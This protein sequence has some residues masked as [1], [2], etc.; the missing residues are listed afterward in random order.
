MKTLKTME[1]VEELI[2]LLDGIEQSVMDGLIAEGHPP[3]TVDQYQAMCV[4]IAMTV[5]ALEKDD[6]QEE[7][8]VPEAL[9]LELRRR[10]DAH[11]KFRLAYEETLDQAQVAFEA[12]VQSLWDQ[13]AERYAERTGAD[14]EDLPGPAIL[15]RH[16]GLVYLIEVTVSETSDDLSWCLMARCWDFEAASFLRDEAGAVQ[17]YWTP[18]A[19]P[20]HVFAREE[21]EPSSVQIETEDV[22]WL[23]KTTEGQLWTVDLGDALTELGRAMRGRQEAH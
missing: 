7:E 1:D 5:A 14:P 4:T 6:E 20:S 12:A 18:T 16:G 21:G 13:M 2:A 23:A 11:M 10:L 8:R 9:A 22:A 3:A 15:S 17:W 19:V